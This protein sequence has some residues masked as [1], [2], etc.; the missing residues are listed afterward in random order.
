MSGSY[1]FIKQE[2]G[3]DLFFHSN[4]LVGV[5][6]NSLIEGQAVEFEKGPG[7][8]GRTQATKVRLAEAEVNDGSGDDGGESGE[9]GEGAEGA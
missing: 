7:R 5:E 1:G 6:F 2:S 3:D 9:G 8:D 4:D